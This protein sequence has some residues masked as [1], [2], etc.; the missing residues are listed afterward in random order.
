MQRRAMGVSRPARRPQAIFAVD[1][2]TA[3]DP[4]PLLPEELGKFV[5]LRSVGW[6]VARPEA[7]MLA[8][9]RG[10]MHWRARHRFCGVCGACATRAA[11][12]T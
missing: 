5:D 4:V 10:L 2:S 6:G 3:E 7:S 11:R 1:I 8:H 12:A 9:A